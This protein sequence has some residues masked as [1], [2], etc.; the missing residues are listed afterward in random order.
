MLRFIVP[1]I[2]LL[3]LAGCTESDSETATVSLSWMSPDQGQLLA[4]YQSTGDAITVLDGRGGS[5]GELSLFVDGITISSDEEITSMREST[6]EPVLVTRAEVDCVEITDFPLEQYCMLTLA[7]FEIVPDGM[8][9]SDMEC[10]E[11]HMELTAR[12]R[13]NA[14]N[15]W[16]IVGETMS[17]LLAG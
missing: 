9:C 7:S 16:A 6:V 13:Q 5:Y 8:E 10:G 4:I 15:H 1:S 3:V 14:S 11:A 17:G 12:L 2:A